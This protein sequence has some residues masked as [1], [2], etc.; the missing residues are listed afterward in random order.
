M[1]RFW[2]YFMKPTEFAGGLDGVRGGGEE[3]D[4]KVSDLSNGRTELPC[5]EKE[6]A[7]G[8]SMM[9]QNVK[10][11]N[12]SMDGNVQTALPCNKPLLPR[13]K[14]RVGKTCLHLAH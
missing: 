7:V 8:G 2:M 4:S 9:G 11:F 3:N 14:L 5:I 6:K 12:L 10:T 1:V 13:T